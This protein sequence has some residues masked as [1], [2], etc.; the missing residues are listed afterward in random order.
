MKKGNLKF[1]QVSL[2]FDSLVNSGASA[3]TLDNQ[4]TIVYNV[5]IID[6]SRPTGHQI[7]IVSGVEYSQFWLSE[8]PFTY[9]VDSYV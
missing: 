8:T 3:A 9:T 6:T 2:D 7:Y 5:Y 1:D 4:I